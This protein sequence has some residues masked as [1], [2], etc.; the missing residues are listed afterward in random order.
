[1]MKKSIPEIF[2]Q[3]RKIKIPNE[4]QYVVGFAVIVAL[5]ALCHY[6]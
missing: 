4:R 2:G 6:G 5:L 1:M 3:L